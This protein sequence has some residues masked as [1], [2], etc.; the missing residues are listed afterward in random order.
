[1][2]LSHRLFGRLAAI[3]LAALAMTG[4]SR[5]G[6]FNAVIPKDAGV[7]LVARDVAYGADPRQ[8]L[9]VY[10][11]TKLDKPAGMIVFV[12]GG[13]WNSGSKSDY[14]FAARALAA[15]G[16]VTVVFDYRLVPAIRYPAFVQDTARALAWS[17]R[18]AG[19]Y[20][21]DP[22]HVYLLGHSAGAYNAMMVTLAPEFLR[23]EGLSPSIIRAAAGL[24]GPYDFLPLAVDETRQAFAGVKDLE[25]TQPINRVRRGGD[26]PPI[27]VATGDADEFVYPRNT[28]KLAA[29]LRAAGHTVEEKHYAGV[30][31]VGPLLALSRPLRGKA[32]VLDDVTGFFRRH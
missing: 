5:L 1:M 27:L 12:Y 31:H 24:S 7:T 14:A 8:T 28:A 10:A 15:R 20:G 11:P 6:A 18:N 23:A 13:S 3:L 2:H 16:Y 29:A 22:D 19:R 25:R 21:A 32:P 4:C 30:D 9:D 26:V 17:W